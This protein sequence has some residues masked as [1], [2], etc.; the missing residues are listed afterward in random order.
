MNNLG[1]W[2]SVNGYQLDFGSYDGCGAINIVDPTKMDWMGNYHVVAAAFVSNLPQEYQQTA[3][4][5][6]NNAPRPGDPGYATY[7]WNQLSATPWH[8]YFQGMG[9]QIQK[10]Y[11]KP[12]YT[13]SGS[14][15]WSEVMNP[16]S[17]LPNSPTGK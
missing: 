4:Q 11:N 14:D 9:E 17:V 12:W 7:V 13:L 8:D 10:E 6:A 5:Q 16:G 2:M 1:H 3:A 15:W